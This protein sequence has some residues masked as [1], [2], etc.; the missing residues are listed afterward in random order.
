MTNFTGGAEAVRAPRPRKAPAQRAGT[1]CPPYPGARWGVAN[2]SA[3]SSARVCAV[4]CQNVNLHIYNMSE[5]ASHNKGYVNY[6]TLCDTK[7]SHGPHDPARSRLPRHDSSGVAQG[8]DRRDFAREDGSANGQAGADQVPRSRFS[9]PVLRS[10]PLL[11]SRCCSVPASKPHA[12]CFFPMWCLSCSWISGRTPACLARWLCV[13]FALGL[14]RRVRPWPFAGFLFSTY[15]R[16][17]KITARLIYRG[18]N[19]KNAQ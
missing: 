19:F 15:D 1:R 3:Q 12:P 13:W 2:R 8:Q 11:L 4:T 16:E 18:Q 7:S 5:T 6:R 17:K 9:F 10:S 14:S